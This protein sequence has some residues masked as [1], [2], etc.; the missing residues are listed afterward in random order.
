MS[1]KHLKHIW[2]LLLAG[3]YQFYGIRWN[4]YHILL[5]KIRKSYCDEIPFF[6]PKYGGQKCLI[7]PAMSEKHLKHKWKLILAGLYQFMEYCWNIYHMLFAK[8]RKLLLSTKY[9]FSAQKWASKCLI[10]PVMSEKHLRHIWNLLL[11]G[12]YQFMEYV[13]IS[14]TCC[15]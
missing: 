8:I 13:G 7:A 6:G 1:E 9:P 4:I 10:A 2:N 12:F 11:A 15:L 3:L 5:V 14:I